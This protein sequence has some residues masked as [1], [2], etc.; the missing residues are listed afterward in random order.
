MISVIYARIRSDYTHK[1]L[2][3]S[4]ED[5]LLGFF[6]ILFFECILLILCT[7]QEKKL[8]KSSIPYTVYVDKTYCAPLLITL[9]N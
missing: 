3:H 7:I 5:A 9:V 8:E 4:P 1:G 2:L 6:S